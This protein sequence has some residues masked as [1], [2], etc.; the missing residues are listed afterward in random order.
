MDLKITTEVSDVLTRKR[1]KE[2]ARKATYRLRKKEKKL[3]VSDEDLKEQKLARKRNKSR[4]RK[5]RQ[6]VRE[7]AE[8]LEKFRMKNL[9]DAFQYRV[10]QIEADPILVKMK[11]NE[12]KS[13]S[14][15]SQRE[16]NYSLVKANQNQRKAKSRRASEKLSVQATSNEDVEAQALGH[17]NQDQEK[18]E[19]RLREEFFRL[20]DEEIAER[21]QLMAEL[22]EEFK[23]KKTRKTK[24]RKFEAPS[25]QRKSARLMAKAE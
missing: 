13:K 24:K 25:V 7:K 9:E 6:R 5:A 23:V 21:N 3:N 17:N 10:A 18:E 4:L 2:R 20:R 14:I 1:E 16:A 22:N 8:D 19:D 12:R 15:K 11:Q